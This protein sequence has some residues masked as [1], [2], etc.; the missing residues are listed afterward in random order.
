MSFLFSINRAISEMDFEDNGKRM[1][2]ASTD[3]GR[4]R[5]LASLEER[6]RRDLSTLTAR[7]RASYLVALSQDL[8]DAINLS[9]KVREVGEEVVSKKSTD[10]RDKVRRSHSEALVFLTYVEDE[11]R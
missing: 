3:S 8:M 5:S 1:S 10:I 2:S 9:K 11:A 6:D 4:P 7:E